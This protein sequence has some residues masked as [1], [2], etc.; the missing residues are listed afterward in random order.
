VTVAASNTT[1]GAANDSDTGHTPAAT[2]PPAAS[3]DRAPLTVET[4]AGRTGDRG[5][6]GMDRLAWHRNPVRMFGSAG[7]WAATGYLASYLPLG[8]VFFGVCLVVLVVSAVLNI[9]WL[10]LPLLIGA[11][12]V[13]RGCATVERVRARLVGATIP[14]AYQPVRGTGVFTHLRTRWHDP[15]TWRDCAYLLGLFPAL[16]VLDVVGLAIWLACLAGITVPIWYWS[17]T[18]R[19]SDG[20]IR[21][22][23]AIGVL[24]NGPDGAGGFGV[25]IGGLPAALVAA[26]VS[27]ALSLL[28]CYLVVAAAR[29]HRALARLV[30]GPYVDPLA[31]AKRVLAGPGPLSTR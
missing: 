6:N 22:G 12:A 3:G 4:P 23:L 20:S 19:W 15:A 30:L 17:V 25:W 16:L 31:E 28:A 11:A 9:T 5:V 18:T 10:G 13:V 7:P 29:L 1:G 8:V 27:V 2:A 14:A 24:P 21:H 26:V